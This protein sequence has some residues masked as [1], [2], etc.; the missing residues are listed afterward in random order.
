[1]SIYGCRVG[2]LDI[3]IGVFE[4]VITRGG[5]MCRDGLSLW[6]VFIDVCS[7]DIV[8]VQVGLVNSRVGVQVKD[9]LIVIVVQAVV[10]LWRGRDIE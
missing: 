4:L 6:T 2:G 3:R 10:R 9:F 8:L 5:I 7:L 1:M